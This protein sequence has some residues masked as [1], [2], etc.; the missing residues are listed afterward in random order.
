MP[1]LPCPHCQVPIFPNEI[2]AGICPVCK[3]S[4][5]DDPK[6][7]VLAEEPQ[8]IEWIPNFLLPAPARVLVRPN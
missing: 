5:D 1:V 7:E 3:E 4:L 2:A 6:P 8:D